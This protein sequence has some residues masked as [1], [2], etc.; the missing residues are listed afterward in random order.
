MDCVDKMRNILA[1]WILDYRTE[2]FELNSPRDWLSWCLFSQRTVRMIRALYFTIQ[3]VCIIGGYVKY[4]TGEMTMTV[5]HKDCSAITYA[6]PF[7][8]YVDYDIF[9]LYYIIL[10]QVWFFY[11]YNIY[12][13]GFIPPLNFLNETP[14]LLRLSILI[15]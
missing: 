8:I 3:S 2:C 6:V 15:K 5:T 11:L 7:Y 13:D 4:I 9:I 12:D 10:Y 1:W 14:R